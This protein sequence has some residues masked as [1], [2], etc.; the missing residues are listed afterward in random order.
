MC[1]VTDR[2]YGTV[3]SSLIALPSAERFGEKPVWLFAAGRPGE[4]TFEPVPL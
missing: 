1:V 3:S 2:G 4:A